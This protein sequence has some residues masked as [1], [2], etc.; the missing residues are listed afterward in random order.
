MAR[1]IFNGLTDEQAREFANWFEGQGEQDISYW[2]E[3]RDIPPPFTSQISV[4]PNG[5]VMVDTH[6]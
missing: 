5:D 6:S 4:L 2:F 1:L 3:N